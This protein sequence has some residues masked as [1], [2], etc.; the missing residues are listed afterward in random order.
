MKSNF[1]GAGFTVRDLPKTERP[2]ERK[3]QCAICSKKIIVK[4][5]ADK[6]YEGG[7]YFGK[8][9]L[10]TEEEFNRALKAG[11]TTER[12]GKTIVGILKKDPKPYRHTEYWEC[13]G[14]YGKAFKE[15]SRKK[16]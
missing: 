13:E 16:E 5:F 8:I 11:V 3:R 10:H 2:R 1:K 9:P 6:K 14:C 12:W 4:I 15:E 7:H